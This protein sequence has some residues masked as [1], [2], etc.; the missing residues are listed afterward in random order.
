MSSLASEIEPILPDL[1]AALMLPPEDAKARCLS[2]APA[3][4][5]AKIEGV[6]HIATD[7]RIAHHDEPIFLDVVFSIDKHGPVTSACALCRDSSLENIKER[8]TGYK[9]LRALLKY[10]DKEHTGMRAVTLICAHSLP[11][12]L[13]TLEDILQSKAPS[14]ARHDSIYIERYNNMRQPAK[15]IDDV[16]KIITAQDQSS[17]EAKTAEGLLNAFEMRFSLLNETLS[18][19][20]NN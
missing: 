19:S 12:A 15:L 7:M 13:A 2:A 1:S 6:L 20:I 14:A 5:R 11:S 17:E 8:T 18:H 9:Q 10:I 4:V 3:S 16:R